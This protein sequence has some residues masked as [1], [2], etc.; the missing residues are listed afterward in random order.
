MELSWGILGPDMLSTTRRTRTLGLG[1]VVRSFNDLAVP[2]MGGVWFG[3]QIVLALLGIDLA[4]EARARGHKVSNIQVANAVEALGCWSAL[5]NSE[6]VDPRV[7]GRRKLQ[8]RADVSFRSLIRPGA[9]VTQPMRMATGQCLLALDLVRSSKER[10]NS[11]QCTD[12][13]LRLLDVAFEGFSPNRRPVRS[14]LLRWIDGDATCVSTTESRN[15]LASNGA[16]NAAAREIIKERVVASDSS[17]RRQNLLLWMNT[18]SHPDGG[19]STAIRWDK[20]PE[21]IDEGHWRDLKVGS[22]FFVARTNAISV[23]DTIEETIGGLSDRV[24]DIAYH[25]PRIAETAI[26]TLQRSADAFLSSGFDPSPEGQASVFCAQCSGSVKK[27]AV[28]ASLVERDDRVL[29]LRGTQIVP[30][31]AFVGRAAA[32]T[33]DDTDETTSEGPIET[34]GASIRWPDGISFRLPNLHLLNA[35]LKGNLNQVLS[36]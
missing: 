35:D 31:P 18:L 13:A 7:R 14:N 21:W 34:L 12:E 36:S 20:K 26:E 19:P 33:V 16:L 11:Y 8:G 27:A 1:S 23:L 29:R 2:G 5:Q 10:F 28:V 15:A 6:A 3:R 32:R 9:Y 25:V 24:L 4:T 30:G 17:G 22:E